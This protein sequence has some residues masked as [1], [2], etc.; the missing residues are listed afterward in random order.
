MLCPLCLRRLPR[1]ARFLLL[2]LRH[3]ERL[4]RKRGHPVSLLRAQLD[5]LRS[6]CLGLGGRL[7]CR[8]RLVLLSL[9]CRVLLGEILGLLLAQLLLLVLLLTLDLADE[10]LYSRLLELELLLQLLGA[11]RNRVRRL[12]FDVEL[13]LRS[14]V[15]ILSLPQHR[16][17]MSLI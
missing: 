6:H 8:L 17:V 11:N 15:Q 9:N 14:S 16:L 2:L 3:L 13:A 10:V 12:L 1:Q 5:H 7:P 4:S